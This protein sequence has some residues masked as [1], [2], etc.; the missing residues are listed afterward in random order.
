VEE[1]DCNQ[2]DNIKKLFDF[3]EEKMK[4]LHEMEKRQI[5]IQ[6]D[7]THIKGRIDN[8]MSHTIASLN[9]MLIKLEPT[10]GHHA[11]II[12]RIEGIGWTLSTALLLT[13]IGLI[14]WAV[15]HGFKLTL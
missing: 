12:K 9:S 13:L 15:A 8:G 10:I 14:G 2:K 5:E 1:H 3:H 7:V 6:G 11:D 4:Q